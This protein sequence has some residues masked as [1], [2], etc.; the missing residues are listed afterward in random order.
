[1]F[2]STV[3]HRLL[4]SCYGTQPNRESSNIHIFHLLVDWMVTDSLSTAVSLKRLLSNFLSSRK[5]VPRLRL[6]IFRSDDKN[7]AIKLWTI[8]PESNLDGS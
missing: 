8:K 6:V 3:L 1:M 7:I 4:P 5:N 2:K